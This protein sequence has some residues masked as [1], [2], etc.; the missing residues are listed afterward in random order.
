[1]EIG[2]RRDRDVIAKLIPICD[3]DK[4]GIDRKGRQRA[5]ARNGNDKPVGTGAKEVG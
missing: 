3:I 4:E 5:I 2:A 1:M